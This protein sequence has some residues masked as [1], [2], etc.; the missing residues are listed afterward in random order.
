MMTN[1]RMR[2]LPALL[3]NLKKFLKNSKRASER[4][5][6]ESNT[7]RKDKR[8]KSDTRGTGRGLRGVMS[9]RV[10]IMLNLSAKVIRKSYVML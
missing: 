1:L 2:S 7:S 10:L 5:E 3:E 6:G 9:V 4:F 8:E